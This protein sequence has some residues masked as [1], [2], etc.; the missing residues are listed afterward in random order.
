M[1]SAADVRSRPPGPV[2]SRTLAPREC[3]PFTALGWLTVNQGIARVNRPRRSAGGASTRDPSPAGGRTRILR[4]APH[5]RV[6]PLKLWRRVASDAS[7]CRSLQGRKRRVPDPRVDPHEA[8]ETTPCESCLIEL[9]I[10][11]RA[12]E[13][14][15]E[16]GHAMNI[17]ESLQQEDELES[18]WSRRPKRIKPKR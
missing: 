3:V 12:R 14:K 16:Q 18:M 13:L 7:I 10:L 2:A 11:Q 6:L 17:V 4:P 5:P 9:R 15:A 8:D 1:I